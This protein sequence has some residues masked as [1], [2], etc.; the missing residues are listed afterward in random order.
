MGGIPTSRRLVERRDH[1]ALRPSIRRMQT[2]RLRFDTQLVAPLGGEE[3]AAR[4]LREAGFDGAFTFEG[5]H[6]VFFPLV[7]AARAGT[8][9]DLMTNVAIAL[10]RS[11]V[12][13][14]HAA[15]DLQVLSE[16]RF[17]LGLGSQV[18]AQVENRYGSAWSHPVDRMREWVEAITAIFATWEGQGRLDY[19]GEYTRHTLMTP[20]FNPGPNP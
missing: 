3:A 19:R 15:W 10:P 12:H 6:D 1:G 20:T 5:A 11:P 7:T 2:R 9:L 16:G 18:R 13:L 17:R 8:G 14:A 4:E